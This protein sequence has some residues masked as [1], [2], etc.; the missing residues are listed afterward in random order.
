MTVQPNPQPR[1]ILMI[2]SHSMGVGDVLRSSAAWRALHE[3]FP[4][5]RL[6]LLFLSKHAGY[7]TEGLIREHHLLSG[8]HF[9]TIRAGDPSQAKAQ[10]IS[11]R[12]LKAQ[13]QAI[14]REVAPD[15]VI[16]FEASGL[17]STLVARWAAQACG[18][19]TL[20]IAEFAGRG[21]LYDQAAP[22]VQRYRAQRNLPQRMDYTNRDFVAL[23]A[24]GIERDGRPIELQRTADGQQAIERLT[25]AW[26]AGL[27]VV[28]LNIG[29]GT[30]DAVP[31]RP[32]IDVV[33][34]AMHQV[35]QDQP[36]VLLLT[37]APFEKAVNA[38][39]VAQYRQRHGQDHIL[40]DLAGA[41][42]LSGLTGLIQA[43]DVF[44][45]SD[46]G[47]Y[48]MAVAMRKPTVGW[49]MLE[50]P[51]AYHRDA[52]CRCLLRPRADAVSQAVRD[53]CPAPAPRA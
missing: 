50:E 38:D 4:G 15:W 7:P 16:D 21:W 12:D 14:A 35:M 39:F 44:V 19:R 22:S 45:S 27:R 2:K 3:R 43:C 49:F 52:W 30:P 48:H 6:H 28:G 37:G 33:V 17:R 20:G 51:T 23:A 5:V 42:S 40:I 47:P 9:V 26:P 11:A 31:K 13:V 41:T 53:L 18:A 29:C 1:C 36:S 34:E 10:R 8:A 46:S 32:P 24:W 25:G